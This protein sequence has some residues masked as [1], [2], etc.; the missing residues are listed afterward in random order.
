MQSFFKFEVAAFQRA[1]LDRG[2]SPEKPAQ[3]DSMVLA[4]AEESYELIQSANYGI[5]V[6]DWSDREPWVSVAD[7]VSTSPRAALASS[8]FLSLLHQLNAGG[9]G[10]SEQVHENI[11]LPALVHA[12]YQ[13]WQMQYLRRSTS[14]ASTTLASLQIRGNTVCVVNCGDSRVWRIRKGG[15]GISQIEQLSRDHTL[16]QEML[17]SGEVDS[18]QHG[19]SVY[20][21]LTHCLTLGDGD[22]LLEPDEEDAPASSQFSLRVWRGTIQTG[23]IYLLATDGLH[24]MSEDFDLERQWQ[25]SKTLEGNLEGLLRA[26]RAHEGN[27]DISVIAISC[28]ENTD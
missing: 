8:S 11:E 6:K 10:L 28:R 9:S 16:W 22:D 15:D 26:W 24:G 4:A 23:D 27:D 7:G 5:A 14:G 17:D 19:A 2:T 21:A 3:Q 18:H 12:A 20:Q 25:S 13:R 1:Y